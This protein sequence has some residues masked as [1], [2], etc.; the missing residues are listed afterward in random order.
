MAEVDRARKIMADTI[1]KDFDYVAR[2]YERRSYIL[3][4]RYFVTLQ[5]YYRRMTKVSCSKYNTL[6]PCSSNQHYIKKILSSILI[7]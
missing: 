4:L 6:F 3:Q 7:E 2:K 5:G 1:E